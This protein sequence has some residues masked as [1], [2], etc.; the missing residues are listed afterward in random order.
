V[1][2]TD[3]GDQIKNYI[4]GHVILVR[5]RQK[6]NP[7]RVLVRKYEGKRPLGGPRRRRE[8]NVKMDL[9]QQD[10]GRRADRTGHG[11]DT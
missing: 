11:G 10:K 9:K 6:R 4:I 8:N 7:Y 1:I 3:L 5:M 2:F